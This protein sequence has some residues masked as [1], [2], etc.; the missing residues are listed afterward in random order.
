MELHSLSKVKPEKADGMDSV[1]RDKLH[2]FA[3][4]L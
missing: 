1:K 2:K 3:A 4:C